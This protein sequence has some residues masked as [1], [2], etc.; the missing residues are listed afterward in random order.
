MLVLDEIDKLGS[1]YRG[2]PSAALLEA[3]DGEQNGSFRD[4]FLE[5]PFDLSEVLFITTANTADTIRQ[6]A[7]A[8][9]AA[10]EARPFRKPAACFG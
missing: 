4:H 9:E 5:I 10:D 3:L 2:D 8:A 7:S 1:D 6:A